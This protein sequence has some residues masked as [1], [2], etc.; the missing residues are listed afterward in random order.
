MGQ[1][2]ELQYTGADAGTQTPVQCDELVDTGWA[3][4]SQRIAPMVLLRVQSMGLLFPLESQLW[5]GRE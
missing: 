4:I 1:C 2:P 3:A 5:A